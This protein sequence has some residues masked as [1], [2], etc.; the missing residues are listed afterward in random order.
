M[1]QQA[2]INQ[3]VH[4][5]NNGHSFMMKNPSLNNTN[6]LGNHLSNSV[7]GMNQNSHLLGNM[8]NNHQ[9]YGDTHLGHT[10]GAINQ[11]NNAVA[12]QANAIIT[13]ALTDTLNNLPLSMNNNSKQTLNISGVNRVK[14]KKEF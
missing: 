2:M 10:I 11:M 9:N 7:L 3:L 4:Q 6:L 12:Q 14:Q 1:N 5:P 13:Q 8:A